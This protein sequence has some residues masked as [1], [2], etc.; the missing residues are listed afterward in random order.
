MPPAA[1]S[2][3]LHG[4]WP[5]E[6]G[7]WKGK[8]DYSLSFDFE[9]P[10]LKGVFVFLRFASS[11]WPLF[12]ATKKFA[13]FPGRGRRV[14]VPVSS[15]RNVGGRLLSLAGNRRMNSAPALVGKKNL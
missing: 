11:F 12:L 5:F 10:N 15:G 1:G 13:F 6:V 8:T 7:R 14:C 9:T 3:C 4:A 2:G